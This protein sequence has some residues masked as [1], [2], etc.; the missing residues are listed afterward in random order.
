MQHV[1]YEG[2]EYELVGDWRGYW[3]LNDIVTDTEVK[4]PPAACTIVEDES[5]EEVAS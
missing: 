5:V 4:A 1:M 2:R 3:V